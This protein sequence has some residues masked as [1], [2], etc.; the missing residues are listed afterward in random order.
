MRNSFILLFFCF[1]ILGFSQELNCNVLVNAQQTGDENLPIFKTLQKQLN[2][3]VNNTK[4]TNKTFSSQERIDCSMVINVVGYS[5]ESFQASLQVQSSRPVYGSSFTTP[6]YNFNDKDFNFKYLEFQNLT[7]N[8]TQYESNLV[9]V[10][11]FHVYMVLGLDADTFS[12]NG[13][14]AYFKQAQTIANYS[15]Q[16]NYKGWKLADGLQS[17]FALIDNL[18]SPTFKEFRQVM[19][20][21]HRQGLDAMSNN[22]K[23]GKEQIATALKQFQAM[24]S[25]RPNSFLIRTFFD[26][27]ADEIEQIFSDGPNV[28]IASVKET[29]QKVAPMHSS[30][31]QNIK[32]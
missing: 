7:F 3:F 30:K 32:F 14:E 24:N 26:A 28:N 12:E 25:R 4:W 20:S 17:R 21:Y 15:Q 31:W 5:G 8:P 27:K 16:E 13:G 9:S 2:E 23:E 11:A 19:Y 6:I 22:V 18:L 1:G 10:L 29:L